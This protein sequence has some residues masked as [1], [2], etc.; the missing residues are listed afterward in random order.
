MNYSLTVYLAILK[1]VILKVRI[2]ILF[3]LNFTMSYM[4]LISALLTIT[5]EL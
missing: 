1:I 5:F 2:V 3:E 4:D